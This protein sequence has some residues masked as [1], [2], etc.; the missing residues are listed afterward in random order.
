M[1]ATSE[2]VLRE[3]AGEYLL[4]PTGETA[5]KIHGM[6]TLSESGLLL[7]K[8]LQSECTEDSLVEALLAEYEVDPATARAD[9][10]AFLEKMDEAGLLV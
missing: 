3:I 9:V 8:K 5:L 1:R 2:M 7:W 6:V 4:I 10:C